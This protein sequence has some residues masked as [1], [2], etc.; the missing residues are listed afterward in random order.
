MKPINAS[1]YDEFVVLGRCCEPGFVVSKLELSLVSYPFDWGLIGSF[2]DLCTIIKEDF[3]QFNKYEVKKLDEYDKSSIH[4]YNTSISFPHATEKQLKKTINKKINSFRQLLK[5]KKKVLFIIKSHANKNTTP[6][7]I[8]LLN[9]ILKSISTTMIFDILLV[10]E[11]ETNDKN[12]LMNYPNNCKVYN[13]F[14]QIKQGMS[15]YPCNEINHDPLILKKWEKIIFK[16]PDN[17][18]DDNDDF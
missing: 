10:N 4:L 8:N 9:E 12:I 6:N 17:D 7:E 18:S 11:Y 15:L 16:K 3:K 14:G 2:N 13:I 5:T 1:E